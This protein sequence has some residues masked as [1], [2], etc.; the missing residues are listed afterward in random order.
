MRKFTL[1]AFCVMLLSMV[2]IAQSSRLDSLSA[3]KKDQEILQLKDHI[4]EY[5]KD[6][7]ALETDLQEKKKKLHELQLESQSLADKNYQH[8]ASL[9]RD[10]HSKAA[11]RRADKAASAARQ[12]AKRVRKAESS[13][14]K[15][16][17]NLNKLK[18]K[19]SKEE[20]K[21]KQLTAM[22]K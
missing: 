5:K 11:T 12:A 20:K 6:S 19:L 3:L 10:A 18:K 22:E 13:V 16:E 1:L 2:G 7:L 21:L 8:A 14:N 17:K 9:R 4:T 15:T